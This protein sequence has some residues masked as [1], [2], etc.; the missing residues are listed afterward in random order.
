MPRP[1][2]ADIAELDE[3][4]QVMMARLVLSGWRFKWSGVDWSFYAPHGG[5]VGTRNTLGHAIER[6]RELHDR[7]YEEERT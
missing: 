3:A 4:R 5:Y 7:H 2:E 6:V 1:P